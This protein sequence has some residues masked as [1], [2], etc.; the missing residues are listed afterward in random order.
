MGLFREDVAVGF[1]DM[2]DGSS[3][4]IALGERR[5]RLKTSGPG[6]GGIFDV[7]AA[8]TYGRRPLGANPATSADEFSD[9][10]GGG[11]IKINET[12]FAATALMRRGFSS[13]HPGGAQFALGDG[14]VRFIADTVQHSPDA[15]GSCLAPDSTFE[16][17]LAI[18]DGNPVGDY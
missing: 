2:L 1:R 6:G 9:V 3:N 8:N 7:G 17:L 5:W 10:L 18:Q 15:I 12:L 11:M 13:Q 16:H 4:V 14:S